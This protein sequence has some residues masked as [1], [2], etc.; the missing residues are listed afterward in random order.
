MAR[1][2]IVTAYPKEDWHSARLRAACRGARVPA[3]TL[4]PCDFSIEC[5]P[6]GPRGAVT[7]R[8]RGESLDRYDAF[9]LPRAIGEH[10]DPDVQLEI[11]RV[12]Q[13]EGALL[14][15][16]VDALLSAIDKLHTSYLLLKAG[17]PT[18]RIVVVQR[19]EEAAAALAEMGDAVVKPIFGSLG[20]GVERL[21]GP[22]ARVRQLLA[23]R[24][25]SHGALYLQEYQRSAG[26][27][28]D[29]RVFIVGGQVEAA[30]ART[31]R[32]GDFRTNIHQGGH[33][34]AWV[35]P[36]EAAN[37]AVRAAQV[38]GLDYAGVDLIEGEGGY[39]ILEVNGTPHWAGIYTA[40]GRDMADAIVALAMRRVADR[41]Q[42]GEPAAPAGGFCLNVN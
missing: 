9:L 32:S 30:I 17:L 34:E 38:L 41:E 24:L 39:Q 18:P 16:R 28:R 36:Q 7:I 19:L 4:D 13:R 25:R 35:P 2:G 15:N 42:K 10:G 6:Q 33:A 31:A 29:L 26:A 8:V 1:L 3:R 12:M 14:I 37:I 20:I 11:Y 40:T 21:Q 22:S 23:Q 5:Q 27:P